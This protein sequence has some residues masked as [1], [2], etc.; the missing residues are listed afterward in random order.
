MHSCITD[1]QEQCS[2]S[3]VKRAYLGFSRRTHHRDR[4]PSRRM[5]MAQTRLNA[6][7]ASTL[8]TVFTFAFVLVTMPVDAVLAGGL[9]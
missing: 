1:L 4:H 3:R 5:T 9:A 8:A 6:L 2:H 7:F